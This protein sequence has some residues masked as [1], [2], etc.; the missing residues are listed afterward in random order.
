MKRRKSILYS[1]LKETA[2]IPERE[3]TE[4][5]LF[6]QGKTGYCWLV[7]ALFFLSERT[8]KEKQ[9]FSLEY[10]MFYDKLEKANHFLTLFMDHLEEPLDSPD[11]R[12]LLSNPVSDRGQWG[13][14]VSLIRKYG[15]VPFREN[16]SF[17]VPAPTG[18]LNTCLNYMLRCFAKKIRES[19]ENGSS[20]QELGEIKEEAMHRVR[21]LLE[22]YYGFPIE[23]IEQPN[24]RSITPQE[25][26]ELNFGDNFD[27]YISIIS[28]VRIKSGQY[29][30]DLDGN[31]AGSVPNK[32]LNLP[33]ETFCQAIDEQID[34]EGCCW[35]TAD[36]GKF[37]VRGYDLF[38]DSI[39][40]L[41]QICGDVGCETLNRSD[42]WNYH[43]GGLAHTMVFLKT[44]TADEEYYKAFNSSVSV[45]KGGIC[46]V[47][48]SWFQ[49][50]VLQA[51]VNKKYI[52]E[53]YQKDAVK[54]KVVKPWEFFPVS[55]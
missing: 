52:P 5:L 3:Q 4:A 48:P 31:V 38:D 26:F 47:S 23:R 12:Y 14:A 43:L 24:G 15:L 8:E 39:F 41:A 18:E 19:F 44:P 49:K 33:E 32:F 36:A 42:V 37:Y 45:E 40:D 50:F 51:V 46:K 20:L 28:N 27:D 17:T 29:V 30:I 9:G 34:G 16:G 1:V 2:S 6:A 55:P 10:L 35:F 53:I 11:N 22:D 7:S 13:M 21:N 25:Y 54:S